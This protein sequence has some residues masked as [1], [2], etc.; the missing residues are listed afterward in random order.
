MNAPEQ[1]PLDALHDAIDGRLDQAGQ[2]RLDAH[3]AVCDACRREWMVL[4]RVKAQVGAAMRSEEDDEM[5]A[6]LE[7]RLRR[8]LDAEDQRQNVNEQPAASRSPWRWA[9]W[10]AAAA[11]M[12][13]LTIVWSERRPP[14]VV[15]PLEVAADFRQYAAG[16][17]PVDLVTTEVATL[18]RQLVGAG[19]GF[20]VRVFDF[21]MM[22]FQLAG[23]GVHQV[24]GQRSALFAYR[25]PD[26]LRLLCQ[27]YEGQVAAL[28][29]PTE[30]RTNDGIEFLVYRDGDVTV[31]FWQ[32][33]EIACALAANGDP[34]AAVKLAFAKAVKV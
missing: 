32:E 14:V 26:A 9:G 3:L 29:P 28:P 11:A 16:T 19:L 5:P 13:A 33:G 2:A 8:S 10:A 7:A 15:A 25:G 17:L 12:L 1:H 18:E 20:D 22:D 24:S 27:M 30:R 4:Q 34:E 23:G 21:G 6:D 31:V